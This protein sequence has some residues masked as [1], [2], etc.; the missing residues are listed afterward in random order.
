MH[1]LTVINKEKKTKKRKATTTKIGHY[2]FALTYLNDYLK[3][4]EL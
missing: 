3:K 1:I 4:G 2:Y